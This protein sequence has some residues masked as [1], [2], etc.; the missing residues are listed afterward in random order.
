MAERPALWVST[1]THTRGGIAT[2]VRD[3]QKTPLWTEWNVR[4]IPTHRDGSALDK[5]IAFASGAVCF[6]VELL[7]SRPS[8][9][10]LHT[11]AD[12]SFIRK[13]VLFWISRLA[14]V[15]VVVHVH[16]SDFPGY[17][18]QSPRLIRRIIA[19]TLTSADAVVALG[20]FLA[21]R[22]RVIAPDA[23]ITAIPNA[24]RIA[25]RVAQPAADE[26]VRVVFLGRIGDRKG[27]F[28]LLDAWAELAGEPGFE[29]DWG[30]RATL[31]IA[32]DGD[33]D[34]A[35]RRIDELGL[36][37]SV[38]LSEWLPPEAVVNLLDK[39]HVLVLPSRNEGQPMA[40][41]E[42][43]ARGLCV[44]ASDVGG[45]REMIGD[46]GGIVVPPDDVAAIADALRAVIRDGDL[47]AELGSAAHERVQS[48]FDVHST[49]RRISALYTELCLRPRVDQRNHKLTATRGVV[50]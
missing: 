8:V 7:R 46:G 26:P 36:T 21:E 4:H 20:E 17:Y 13:C 19:R 35:R 44:V 30:T 50:I 45:L 31:T 18:D 23:R 29:A 1:S 41:L 10:H 47:R 34:R 9:V 39:A 33:V 24:V 42:A 43:M 3:M 49:S 14:G 22:L 11:S 6:V 16:A 12:A 40:V 38:R 28:R 2:Y 32:G 27:T 48:R 25:D 15:P 37:H 5:V